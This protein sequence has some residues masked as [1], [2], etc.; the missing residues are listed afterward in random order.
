MPATKDKKLFDDVAKP[1]DTRPLATSRPI[2]TG[3]NTKNLEDPMMAKPVTINVETS[4]PDEPPA[5]ATAVSS[6]T[7]SSASRIKVLPLP[8]QE[9]PREESP[10]KPDEPEQKAPQPVVSE[11]AIVDAVVG[12]A[13][14]TN[15]DKADQKA[16]QEAADRQEALEQAIANKKYFVHI[17]EP[18]SARNL[19]R[20]LIAL[21]LILLLALIG[22]NFAL[23]ANLIQTNIQPVTNLIK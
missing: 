4:S 6:A 20:L 3:H 9:P 19:E 22:F 8:E 23:D 14:L 1:G 18:K 21:L 16:A 13:N 12:Q 15:H 7:L 5:T 11:T 10:A 17:A 2:I